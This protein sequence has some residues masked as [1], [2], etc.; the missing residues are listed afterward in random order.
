[1]KYLSKIKNGF[2]FN[3]QFILR[4]IVVKTGGLHFCSNDLIIINS[5]DYLLLCPVKITFDSTKII[6]LNNYECDIEIEEKE[7]D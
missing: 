4:Y 1:M 3:W 6:E 5:D 2:Y 7:N